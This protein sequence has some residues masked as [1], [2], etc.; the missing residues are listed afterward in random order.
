MSAPLFIHVMTNGDLWV[1][2]RVDDNPPSGTVLS[3]FRVN[4]DAKL[5]KIGSLTGTVGSN[6]VS[7]GHTGKFG[8]EKV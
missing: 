4:S 1:S 2:N 3:V 5:Q 8:T 6:L 7:S